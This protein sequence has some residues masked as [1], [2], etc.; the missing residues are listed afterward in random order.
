[1]ARRIE[2]VFGP[3]PYSGFDSQYIGGVWRTGRR[4]TSTKDIDPYTGKPLLEIPLADARDVDDAYRSAAKA[5]PVWAAM[6]PRDRAS[7]LRSVVSILELR[8][9]E[10]VAWLIHESGSTRIKAESF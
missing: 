8:H 7:V 4:G 3:E 2:Q 1:M 6:L 10:I 9:D 5:Q